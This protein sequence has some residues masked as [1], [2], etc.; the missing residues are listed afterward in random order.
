MYIH[1]CLLGNLIICFCSVYSVHI[2]S[3]FDLCELDQRFWLWYA[4]TPKQTVSFTNWLALICLLTSE[5]HRLDI[6]FFPT[7]PACWLVWLVYDTWR[8]YR[9]FHIP[10]VLGCGWGDWTAVWYVHPLLTD[11]ALADVSCRCRIRRGM[12][13]IID[14]QICGLTDE[15]RTTSTST[16]FAA[17]LFML[18]LSAWRKHRQR[19]CL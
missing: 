10:R 1:V 13:I 14:H 17:R 12:S 19:T 15:R 4:V 5:Q 6:P 2:R 9:V 8:S 7:I 3:V 18:T 11:V 16:C